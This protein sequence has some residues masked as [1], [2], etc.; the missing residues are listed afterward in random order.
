ML[1]IY[2]HL[3]YLSEVM[4][5]H[6]LTVN[7]TR[8]GSFDNLKAEV[9]AGHK[10]EHHVKH[11]L[12]GVG[13]QQLHDVRVFEHVTYCGLSLEVIQAEAGAGG[14]LGHIHDLHGELLVGVTVDTSSYYREGSLADN[15]MDLIDVIEEDLL[16]I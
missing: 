2:G 15:L 16:L 5:G 6:G 9:G 3:Q 1:S 13:L 7:K 10:L 8:C 14:E 12:A 11:P 4:A